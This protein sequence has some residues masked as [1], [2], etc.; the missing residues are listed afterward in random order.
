MIRLF[1]V[2]PVMFSGGVSQEIGILEAVRAGM[3]ELVQEIV[4]VDPSK[5]AVVDTVGY[6]PLHLAAAYAELDILRW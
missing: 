2:L 5:L 6:T 4:R 1:L 3:L